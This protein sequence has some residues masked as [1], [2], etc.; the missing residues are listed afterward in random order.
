[1]TLSGHMKDAPNS[2]S[3]FLMAIRPLMYMWERKA[4]EQANSTL[5]VRLQAANCFQLR[6]I[7]QPDIAL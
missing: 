1:M 7:P 4:A 3:Y 5:S 6:G 2:V